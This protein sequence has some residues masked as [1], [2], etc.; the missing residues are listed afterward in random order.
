MRKYYSDLLQDNT[1]YRRKMRNVKLKHKLLISCSIEVTNNL[2]LEKFRKSL[3]FYLAA[4]AFPV[5]LK[6]IMK[7]GSKAKPKNKEDFESGVDIIDNIENA[8]TKFNKKVLKDFTK[9]P[10]VSVL[11][12]NYLGKVNNTEYQDHYKMLKDLA[13]E[14]IDEFECSEICPEEKVEDRLFELAK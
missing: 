4:I 1:N 7:K 11:L 14:S 5:D 3:P 6:K 13:T 12:L 10:E 2:K 8:L 9:M